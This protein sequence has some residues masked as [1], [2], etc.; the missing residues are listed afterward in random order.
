M[1]KQLQ[2]RFIAISAAVICMIFALI[3]VIAY[4]LNVSSVNQTLDTLTDILSEN[5]GT[6]PENSG[7]LP[8]AMQGSNVFPSFINKETPFS[9]RFFTVWLNEEDEIVATN[10]ESISS[11]TKEDAE[12]YARSAVIKGKERGWIEDYRYKIYDAKMGYSVVFVD[13]SMYRGMSSRFIGTIGFILTATAAMVL[14][15]ILLIS[16]RAIRPIAES[17]EKQKQFVTDVNHELKTP[18]TLIMTNL[19]ILESQLGENEWIDGIRRKGEQMTELVG[20]LVTLSRMDEDEQIMVV[21]KVDL[22][23]C[24]LDAI[25]EFQPLSEEHKKH[26]ESD[27]Q[28]DVSCMGNEEALRRLLSILL[29]NA[30]KYCDEGGEIK[31]TLRHRRQIVLT[32]ENSCRSV[33]DIRLDKLFDRFYRS[34]EARTFGG[35]FGIGLSIAQSIAKKHHGEITAYRRDGAHI[36]FKVIWKH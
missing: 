19:E 1:I 14:I 30:V 13:G 23:E 12:D 27:V 22:S 3:F 24:V 20:Q 2:K 9:T 10:I 34:D 21:S 17:Y 16:K 33:D 18:L 7:G 25:A 29:D 28:P 36:G 5:D 6:F 8:S 15:L 31:I 35:G 11:V 26:M 32:V 4:L